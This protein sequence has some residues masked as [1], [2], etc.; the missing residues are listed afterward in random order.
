[1]NTRRLTFASAVLMLIFGSFVT[2][3]SAQT[4]S[5]HRKHAKPKVVEKTIQA[6]RDLR[7]RKM[8][9]R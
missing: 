5:K 2:T 3:V 9:G 8:P 1:M 4:K 7:D 6:D